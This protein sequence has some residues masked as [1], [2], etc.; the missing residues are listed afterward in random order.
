[1]NL[2]KHY[3]KLIVEHA[4]EFPD[5]EVCGT[6]ELDSNLM[7]K[8]T[9]EKNESIDKK[10]MFSMSP[11]KIL[12]RK[13]LLGIYHSHPN[14]DENP[15]E[16]DIDM[17]EELGI[18]FLIYSLKTKKFF[19]YYPKSYK[20]EDL[21]GRPYVT[22]FYECLSIAKDYFNE[23]R[24]VDVNEWNKNYWPGI[25]GNMDLIEG[26]EKKMFKVPLDEI[27]K[28]D[29]IVF[30]I[31]NERTYHIGMYEG[32][33]HFLHQRSQHFSGSQLLDERWRKKI[34]YVYRYDT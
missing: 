29:L 3:Y 1:M 4:E 17:S 32:N 27:K 19:L 31:R 20:A 26:F 14:S 33:D 34:K 28:H 25:R 10:K 22:G 16:Y 7:V 24:E 6:I 15:S 30:E 18:P 21:A 9:R 12:N 11:V 5:E 13:K 8:V 2:N 23:I